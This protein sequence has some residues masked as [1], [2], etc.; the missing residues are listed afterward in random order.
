MRGFY[1]VLIGDWD[2]FDKYVEGKT[3]HVG[4]KAFVGVFSFVISMYL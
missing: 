4:M 3:A 2:Y 1:N